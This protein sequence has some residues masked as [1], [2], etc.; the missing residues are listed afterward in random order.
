MSTEGKSIDTPALIHD[1]ERALDVSGDLERHPIGTL[2]AVAGAG[3]VLGGGLFTPLT[4]RLVRGALRLGVRFVVLPVVTSVLERELL[5]IVGSL[6]SGP[7][8]DA[9]PESEAKAP[10]AAPDRAKVRASTA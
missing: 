9:H 4:A 8:P 6:V 7:P 2:V 5:G 3:Y 1:V 10:D